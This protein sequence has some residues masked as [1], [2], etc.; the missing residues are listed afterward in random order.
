MPDNQTDSNAP[1]PERGT[2]KRKYESP[3]LT[4]YGDLRRIVMAKPGIRGDGRNVP[5]T[6]A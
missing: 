1:K 4:E 6:K 2:P 3:R 5:A